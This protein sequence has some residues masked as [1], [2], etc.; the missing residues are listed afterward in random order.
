MEKVVQLD[1]LDELEMDDE[2][3]LD[4]RTTFIGTD[5]TDIESELVDDDTVLEELLMDDGL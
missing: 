1:E 4:G 2:V 5:D 3:V